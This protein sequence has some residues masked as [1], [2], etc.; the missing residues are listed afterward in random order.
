MDADVDANGVGNGMAM[1]DGWWAG[2]RRA[3]GC[4]RKCL[5]RSGADGQGGG[6]CGT[7]ASC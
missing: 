7:P 4:G 6:E 3:V 1:G 5:G 2:G